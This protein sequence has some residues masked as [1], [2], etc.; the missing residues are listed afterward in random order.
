MTNV[1]DPNFPLNLTL[2]QAPHLDNTTKFLNLNFD[3][4]FFDTAKGTNHVNKNTVF[5]ERIKGLNSNQI[6]IH[7]SMISS[8]AIAMGQKYFPMTIN[9][10]NATIQILQLFPEI[11]EH[12]GES[13]KADLDIDLTASSGDLLAF[14][15]HA[16]I[17]IGK[18]QSLNVKL[19]IRCS[20]STHE[21]ET[22]VQF[23]F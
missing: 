10:A 12:Y 5:P 7:Q 4:T 16:G 23:D 20:N 21:E 15:Q 18:N 3:G 1:F 2:T 11:K 19:E 22:A 14:N 6:F 17:E 9:D 8:L 13:I